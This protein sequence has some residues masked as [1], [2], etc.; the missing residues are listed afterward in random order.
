MA[1]NLFL[2][3]CSITKSDMYAYVVLFVEDPFLIKV[4]SLNTNFGLCAK[5]EGE[6]SFHCVT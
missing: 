5:Q 3:F 2:H 4:L 6:L 1:K